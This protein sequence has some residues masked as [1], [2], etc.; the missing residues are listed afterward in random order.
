MC[1]KRALLDQIFSRATLLF[2]LIGILDSMMDFW[3]SADRVFSIKSALKAMN[4]S[5]FKERCGDCFVAFCLIG[6]GVTVMTDLVDE[7]SGREH[8]TGGVDSLL[9]GPARALCAFSGSDPA[10]PCVLTG[11][12]TPD[13]TLD[14]ST[15]HWSLLPLVPDLGGRKADP[16]H[17]II[18]RS[19]SASSPSPSPFSF[20]A[21]PNLI[22]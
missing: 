4:G 16:M 6:R 1:L 5:D 2:D 3:A 8:I 17:S 22:F 7:T 15:L 20:D 9:S 14:E 21:H 18:A 11:M 10:W 12:L 13:V 19:S